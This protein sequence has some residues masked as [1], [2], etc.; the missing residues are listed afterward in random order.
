[1]EVTSTHFCECNGR[2]YCTKAKLTQHKKTKT[3]VQWE[4][5]T[6]LRELKIELTKKD[7]KIVGLQID[8]RNLQ[9]LNLMLMKKITPYNIDQ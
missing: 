9:D 3:H 6:E 2:N 5:H 1:M 4:N 8:K 7:N